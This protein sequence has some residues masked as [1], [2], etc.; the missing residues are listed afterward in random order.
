[1]NC[2]WPQIK[3]A[4]LTWVTRDCTSPQVQLPPFLKN[5]VAQTLVAVLQVS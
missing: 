3:A 1:M 2:L 4:L 5:K